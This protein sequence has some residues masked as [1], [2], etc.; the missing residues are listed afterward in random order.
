M[1]GAP[2]DNLAPRVHQ[3]RRSSYPGEVTANVERARQ[4]IEA[5]AG[6]TAALLAAMGRLD[7]S[8]VRGPSLLPRWTR[9]HV[10]SHLARNADA[11]LNLLTWARTG[12]EHPMYTSR[13]DRDAAIDEGSVRG[14]LLLCEDL[15][16]ACARFATAAAA[17][18]AGAWD[19]PLTNARGD[20]ML[21]AE[22]PWLRMREVW[23]HLVDL[24][25]G[26]D[27]DDVPPHL[28]EH[29]LD[30]VV[31]LFAGRAD[32]PSVTVD[33]SLTDGRRRTWHIE[34]SHDGTHTVRGTAPQLL[35][36]LTGRGT[37]AD[38]TGGT[39]ALPPMS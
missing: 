15:T 36:W 10:L 6:A 13:E 14:H 22:V 11:L 8:T 16:A 19:T 21:A 18:P 2:T 9:A 20:T 37:G 33:V 7:D 35:T 30:D 5:A 12:V 17:M 39:P 27:F 4:G 29:L 23:V 34:G 3:G 28:H 24:D 31:G 32:V 25:A 26:V 1:L 38:L